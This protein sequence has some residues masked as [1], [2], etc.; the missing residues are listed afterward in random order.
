MEISP[1]MTYNFI[2][3]SQVQPVFA[4]KNTRLRRKLTSPFLGLLC[5]SIQLTSMIAGSYSGYT[6]LWNWHVLCFSC[7]QDH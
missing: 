6:C 4:N 7:K 1:I 3:M 2:N 5:L